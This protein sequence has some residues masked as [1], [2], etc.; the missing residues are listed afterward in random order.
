MCLCMDD[1]NIETLRVI[2]HIVPVEVKIVAWLT[3]P[4]RKLLTSH[5]YKRNTQIPAEDIFIA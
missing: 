4:Q 5:K 2:D 3:I 1:E